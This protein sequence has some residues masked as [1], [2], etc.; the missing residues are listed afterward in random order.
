[1][2]T[3]LSRSACLAARFA[4]LPVQAILHGLH[5]A[6]RGRNAM[7]LQFR[8]SV[9]VLLCLCATACAEQQTAAVGRPN[10]II[11]REF[12]LNQAAITLDPTFGFSLYRGTPG[13]PPRQ[14]A[15]SAGRA[16]AFN[17]G[18]ASRA[19]DCAICSRRGAPQQ[20]ARSSALNA[21]ADHHA[22]AGVTAKPPR[23]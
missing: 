12:A 14:R 9:A 19:R 10:A 3:P 23:A 1:M 7:R 11:V 16:V 15:A 17:L 5:I 18:G 6:G 2:S 8:T 22:T 20:L 21:A 4:A 13:V